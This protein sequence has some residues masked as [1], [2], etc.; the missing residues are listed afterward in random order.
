ME[1][2]DHLMAEK[3]NENKKDLQMGQVTP[4]KIFKKIRENPSTHYYKAFL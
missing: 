1:K 4:K 3:T 2:M